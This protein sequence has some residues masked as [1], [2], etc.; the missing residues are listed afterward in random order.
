MNMFVA[1]ETEPGVFVLQRRPEVVFTLC[2]AESKRPMAHTS[3]NLTFTLFAAE[4]VQIPR[5]EQR[6]LRTDV[7]VQIPKL[8]LGMIPC[9]TLPDGM[10]TESVI[11]HAGKTDRILIPVKSLVEEATILHGQPIATCSFV[12]APTVNVQMVDHQPNVAAPGQI[13]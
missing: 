8:L 1:R 6:L 7:S 12:Q 11:L 10:M 13:V 3:D 2:S 9:N 5:G 4:T